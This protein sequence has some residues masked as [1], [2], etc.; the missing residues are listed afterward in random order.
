MIGPG[1]PA[2]IFRG[3]GNHLGEGWFASAGA[4]YE[5]LTFKNEI[6]IT[7]MN[8]RILQKK[9]EVFLFFFDVLLENFQGKLN[10]CRNHLSRI[11][12]R[13]A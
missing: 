10:F 3:G 5:F 1:E 6:P 12:N 11:R 7:K 9:F 13:F 4:L 2:G 8:L